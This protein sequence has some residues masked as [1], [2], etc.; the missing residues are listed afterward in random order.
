LDVDENDDSATHKLNLGGEQLLMMQ[1]VFNER[2]FN[3]HFHV[4][5]HFLSWYL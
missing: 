1:K 4:S 5:V 2:K 3:P